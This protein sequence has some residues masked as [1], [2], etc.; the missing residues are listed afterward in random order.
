MVW[1]VKGVDIDIYKEH[2]K[3]KKETNTINTKIRVT[4]VELDMTIQYSV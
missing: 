2:C 1:L 3:N 4:P